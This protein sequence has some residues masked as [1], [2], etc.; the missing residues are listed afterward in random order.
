MCGILFLFCL[1]P[2]RAV[3]PVPLTRPDLL[4]PSGIAPRFFGPNAFPV[5]DL[6]DG[7]IPD[8]LTIEEAADYYTGFLVKGATDITQDVFLR[9]HVPLYSHRVSL[10][11]WMPVFERWHYDASIREARRVEWDNQDIGYDTGDAYF[12]I[13]IWILEEGLHRPGMTLRFVTKTASGNNFGYARFFDAPGYFA[14]ASIGK[15][16]GLFRLSLTGGFLVWQSDN[17]RQDDALL[18]GLQASYNLSQLQLQGCF[19]GYYGWERY[20]DAP[21]TL[22]GRIAWHHGQFEP[23]FLF[24]R[25][26]HDYPFTQLRV[27]LVYHH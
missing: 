1:L 11:F 13:N 7:Q 6:L 12:G 10:S 17:G 21:C 23:Y 22:K 5:P 2:A 25:G 26:L 3:P 8:H 14:D 19:S 9:V 20:G 27:G 4:Y 18:Y 15:G 16:L 24:Q